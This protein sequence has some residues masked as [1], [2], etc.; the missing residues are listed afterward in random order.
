MVPL[1]RFTLTTLRWWRLVLKEKT[2]VIEKE[3]IKC[4]N[5][6]ASSEIMQTSNRLNSK[7]TDC[8]LGSLFDSMFNFVCKKN[9][10]TSVSYQFRK[11]K[12]DYESFSKFP[13]NKASNEETYRRYAASCFIF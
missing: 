9:Y 11:C 10:S 3:I 8:S 1:M 6:N 5:A 4:P 7:R 13:T 2:A 12:I